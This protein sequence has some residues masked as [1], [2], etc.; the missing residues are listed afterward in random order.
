MFDSVDRRA[1]VGEDLE[2]FCGEMTKRNGCHCL[3]LIGCHQHPALGAR[4]ASC[5]F[6]DRA[7]FIQWHCL[8]R[9]RS[10]KPDCTTSLSHLHM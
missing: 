5:N 7:F 4:S 9:S 8:R 2:S 6:C 1:S 10:K 3:G